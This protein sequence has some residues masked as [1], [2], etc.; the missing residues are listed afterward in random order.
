M[1]F[2]IPNYTGSIEDPTGVY[3][4]A[5]VDKVDFDIIAMSA[6]GRSGVSSGC[7]VTAQGAPNNTVAVAAGTV[8]VAGTEVAVTGGNL[9][10]TAAHATLKRFDLITVNNAG[11]K[12]YTAGTAAST[13]VFPAIPANSVVLAAIYIPANDNIINT[14]QII[15]KR[16]TVQT[17]SAS[18][19][20]TTVSKTAD[21]TKVSDTTLADDTVLK[22]TM[23]ASTKYRI[24]GEI[25]VVGNATAD[26]KYGFAGPASPTV[27]AMRRAN[28]PDV[29]AY[30]DVVPD[31]AYPTAITINLSGVEGGALRFSAIVHN[32]NAGTFSFQ[33]AQAVSNAGNTTVHAGSYIEYSVA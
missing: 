14:A 21:Q 16:I 23:A 18:A 4:Q 26:F 3:P 2:T 32:V 28:G 7:A 11:T 12:A 19:G 9:T 30:T 13:P 15:D 8:V 22:F 33:W 17:P 25:W 10:M 27:V 24:R 31:V 29:T 1:A 20:W 5:Q 6:G